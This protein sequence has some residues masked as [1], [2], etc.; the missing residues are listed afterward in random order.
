MTVAELIEKL[1]AYEATGAE[2][3][4]RNA[5]GQ[6]DSAGR[7]VSVAKVEFMDEHFDRSD[8]GPFVMLT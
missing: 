4:V 7:P 5:S 8:A 2:V 6:A 3:L 1:K